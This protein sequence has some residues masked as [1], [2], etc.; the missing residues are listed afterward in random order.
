MNR[1]IK[2]TGLLFLTI[3]QY[4]AVV[5]ASVTVLFTDFAIKNIILRAVIITVLM[6][7]EILLVIGLCHSMRYALSVIQADRVLSNRD[8][9]FEEDEITAQE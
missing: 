4:Q 9:L 6:G 2:E 3:G 8:T 7:S 5:I 1:Q